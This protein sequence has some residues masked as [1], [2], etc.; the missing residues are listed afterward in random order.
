[1]KKKIIA[2]LLGLS[3]SV[4]AVLQPAFASSRASTHSKTK[5]PIVLVHGFLGWDTI[6]GLNYWY[7]IPE[8]L[9]SDGA[10][11]VYEVELSQSNSDVVRGEQLLAQ[12]QQIL[13]TTGAKKVN[14]IGHSQGGLDAR[15]V[16]AVQPEL[17]ASVTTVATPHLGSPVA[18]AIAG[19]G[20]QSQATLAQIVSGLSQLIAWGSGGTQNPE[21][22]YAALAALTSVGT[23]SFNKQYP[24]G[25]PTS[26]RGNGALSVNGIKF[27]SW[28]GVGVNTTALDPTD[29]LFA[30]TA[31][32]FTDANNN[33][34]ASDNDGMVGRCSNHFGK[35][36][37]D[38]YHY[39]H[40]DDV[41]Q[42][43]GLVDSK[44][45]SPVT[46]FENQANR[47]KNAGL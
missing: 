16:A 21:D 11:M 39:N 3:L 8:G 6:A 17:V 31:L 20:T 15:Y 30:L 24:A 13:A 2:G 27:Y 38:N 7:Q 45:T 28:G 10:T 4:G 36:I 47:L 22:V 18:D 35:I 1:M 25:V 40:L 14:L 46:L 23:A 26:C 44:E 32:A 37:K 29:A 34:N 42:F 43:F 5:Y 41:N 33:G 19:A 9:K 12:V